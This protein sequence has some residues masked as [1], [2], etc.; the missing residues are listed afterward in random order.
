MIR[1]PPR[2]TLFPY[3]TLFRSLYGKNFKTDEEVAKFYE[4][5]REKRYPIKN[6]E[7][8][9]IN[10]VGKDLHE[11]FFKHYTRKQWNLDTSELSP[12]VCG[13]IPVRTNEDD[14]YFTDKFQ[15]MPKDGY[16]KMFERMLN[17]N[18]IEIIFNTDYKN[19]LNEDRK[20]VV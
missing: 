13:R 17:H 2:S 9:I 5:V 10:Q 3:T 20:S 16:T 19:I 15:F 6:S 14:R 12:S 18:N 11:K 8:I 4:S 1:R 7:D